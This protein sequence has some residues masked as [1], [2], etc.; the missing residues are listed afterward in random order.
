MVRTRTRVGMP[1]VL[2]F[3]LGSVTFQYIPK[4]PRMLIREK[5]V[6]IAIKVVVL[7]LWLAGLFARVR[8]LIKW[9]R[10]TELMPIINI[11]DMRADGHH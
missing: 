7:M 3:S 5:M 10:P 9:W 2:L 8:G 4:P 6:A 11:R 1:P